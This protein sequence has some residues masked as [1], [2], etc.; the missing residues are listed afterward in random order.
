MSVGQI[1]AI[2]CGHFRNYDLCIVDQ[3]SIQLNNKW[4]F[5]VY[6]Q[7]TRKFGQTHFVGKLTQVSDPGPS[8]P[9]C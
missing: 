5:A 4:G 2:L 1:K 8:C 9:S 3:F 7:L 6:S